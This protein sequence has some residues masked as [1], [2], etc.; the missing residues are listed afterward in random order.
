[1]FHHIHYNGNR[2]IIHS[3]CPASER[4]Y[5]GASSV[6]QHTTPTQSSCIGSQLEVIVCTVGHPVGFSSKKPKKILKKATYLVLKL[7]YF[8]KSNV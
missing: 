4:A 2:F 7:I 8:K 3:P 6:K 5:F 1:M